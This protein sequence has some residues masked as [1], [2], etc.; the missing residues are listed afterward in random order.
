M[1]KRIG[2]GAS[3]ATICTLGLH[4]IDS[5]G[6]ATRINVPCF[7]TTSNNGTLTLNL[8]PYLNIIP[9]IYCMSFHSYMIL[10]ISL[11]E[12]IIA[13]L[14]HSMKG[15]LIGFYYV[16]HYGLSGII[17]LVEFLVFEKYPVYNNSLS[18]GTVYYI[19]HCSTEYDSLHTHIKEI[20]AEGER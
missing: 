15:V 8:S 16:L 19:K 1:L 9:Y 11:I 5:I 13:Q 4:L 3:I 2:I 20:Q 18:S 10:T 6:H 14:P 7:F 12:F 17:I